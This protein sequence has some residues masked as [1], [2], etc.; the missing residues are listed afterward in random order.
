MPNCVGAC[1][2][3]IEQWQASPGYLTWDGSGCTGGVFTNLDDI[4]FDF[5]ANPYG[6]WIDLGN[7]DAPYQVWGLV[8]PSTFLAEF[9]VTPGARYAATGPGPYTLTFSWQF[10]AMG[11]IWAS[12]IIDVRP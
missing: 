10:P 12:K 7:G 1:G 6:V 11:L 3:S 2:S 8:G 9:G 4:C 5:P